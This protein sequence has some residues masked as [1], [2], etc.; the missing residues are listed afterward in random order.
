MLIIN[1]ARRYNELSW[2]NLFNLFETNCSPLDIADKLDKILYE[3]SSDKDLDIELT[4]L[5]EAV[6]SR[7]GYLISK[8]YIT[9]NAVEVRLFENGSLKQKL[10]FSHE[11][12]LKDFPIDFYA[13]PQKQTKTKCTTWTDVFRTL[14]D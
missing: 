6:L 2:T 13:M 8:G 1:I 9:S 4:T 10:E 5:N 14:Y 7:V 12:M 3:L 11:G